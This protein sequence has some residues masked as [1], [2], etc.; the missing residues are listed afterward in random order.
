[1]FTGSKHARMSVDMIS[2]LI[3]IN[4]NSTAI[5]HNHTADVF[6]GPVEDLN[7][8][9]ERIEEDLEAEADDDDDE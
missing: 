1:M 2:K 6:Q 9:K 3:L 8:V 5:H 4:S 7:K